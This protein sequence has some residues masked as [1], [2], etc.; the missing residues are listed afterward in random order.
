MALEK[1]ITNEREA[2]RTRNPGEFPDV[3]HATF[4]KEWDL[5]YGENPSQAAAIYNLASLGPHNTKIISGLTDVRS[6][7]TDSKGKG[8]LSLTN[9]MDICRAMDVLKFFRDKQVVVIM[10]HNIV[11]GFAKIN[12]H[13][14][15]DNLRT[16]TDLFRLARH[17]DLLSN[18][19][20]TTAF[21]TPL[22]MQTAE[23][24]YELREQNPFF[25]DVVAAPEYEEGVIG[26]L[27]RQS[28][29]L[30]IG[31]F[32]HLDKLPRFRGG[33]TYGLLSIK[34]MPSGRFGIQ[35]LFLTSIMRADD[36]VLKPYV[37]KDGE[38]HQIQKVLTP[39]GL[40]DLLTAWYLNLSGARS[41]GVVFVK[42]GV[43]VAMGSGKVARVKAVVDAII[44][45]MQNAMDREGIS[46]DK[47]KGIEGYEQLKDNPFQ[48]A[49]CSSD[50]FFP[51]P[52]SLE[53]IARVGTCAVVQPYG[54]EKD[55]LSIDAANKHGIAMPA[56]LE[57]CFGHW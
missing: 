21:S 20:G 19:G 3:I 2:Y 43:S 46:Y 1:D 40:D 34:E 57:R 37:V 36:F 45:G 39:N 50:A 18:F 23:A 10:K 30:R 41:N 9:T 35:D 27:E 11:S 4:V 42:D 14:I 25:V 47:L 44:S 24:M 22:T 55:I 38:R 56:T 15:S 49:V 7:R 52:D 33:D 53:F 51:F 29:T 8:G 32:S 48:G 16:Q 31:Q 5:K 26:Y 13:N 17:A 12:Y 28:K 54:S 6:V